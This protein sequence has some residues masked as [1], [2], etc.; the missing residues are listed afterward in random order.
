MVYKNE[1]QTGAP[2]MCVCV[3]RKRTIPAISFNV[4]ARNP[5]SKR[6]IFATPA[7]EWRRSTTGK[8]GKHLKIRTQES[9]SR[10]CVLYVKP[11]EN[12]MD[13]L[14]NSNSCTLAA[15]VFDTYSYPQPCTKGGWDASIDSSS[16]I[17]PKGAKWQILNFLVGTMLVF[18]IPWVLLCFLLPAFLPN[19]KIGFNVM[20]SHLW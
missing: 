1:V 12:C 17:E 14:P 19:N 4:L 8:H 5:K 15:V 9:Q 18:R 13:I 7:T 2:Q 11:V 20:L 6:K 3:S 10:A 16:R